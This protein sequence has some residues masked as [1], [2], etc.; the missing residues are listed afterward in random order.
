MSQRDRERKNV[1][2]NRGKQIANQSQ[3]YSNQNLTSKQ[4]QFGVVVPQYQ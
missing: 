2:T 1:D 4:S 3:I